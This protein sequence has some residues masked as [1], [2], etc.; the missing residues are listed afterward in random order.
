M[1]P[2][3]VVR[4][5]ALRVRRLLQVSFH[6]LR[7]Q[8]LVVP[9]SRP[10][11]RSHRR[12]SR[13]R[14]PVRAHLFRRR[15]KRRV[16]QLFLCDANTKPAPS[17]GQAARSRPQTRTPTARGLLLRARPPGRRR[18]KPA[19]QAP[20]GR[21]QSWASTRAAPPSSSKRSPSFRQSRGDP[22]RFPAPHVGGP[23][24][25]A[26]CLH[27]PTS[28]T[29]TSAPHGRR[30]EKGSAEA[31]T[32][33][34]LSEDGF[35]AALPDGR[36]PSRPHGRL[37]A[38]SGLGLR[39]HLDAPIGVL[40]VGPEHQR[41]GT[42]AVIKRPNTLCASAT[43]TEGPQLARASQFVGKGKLTRGARASK[44]R[45]HPAAADGAV[46]AERPPHGCSNQRARWVVN[47]LERRTSRIGKRLQPLRSQRP[48]LD[49]RQ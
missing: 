8:P 12:P 40:V 15:R 13:P 42:K 20:M 9:T 38:G 5:P 48:P 7:R 2:A 25:R 18:E 28:V 41:L 30:A 21:N 45:P 3:P 32:G 44:T 14:S 29:R 10:P 43:D 37:R 22:G 11:R 19:R 31:P 16:R 26:L 47:R 33:I 34:A 35:R 49:C 36:T 46:R 4:R 39:P 6:D 23:L 27:S 1:R 24:H 17:L